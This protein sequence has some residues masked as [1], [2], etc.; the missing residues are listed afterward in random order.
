M[1]IKCR[2]D[3]AFIR[4]DAKTVEQN[5]GQHARPY[6]IYYCIL[7]CILSVLYIIMYHYV[8]YNTEEEWRDGD[9][10]SEQVIRMKQP[11]PQQEDWR[12]R[13]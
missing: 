6:I 13:W 2:N 9:P 7:L 8:Y 10:H 12:E 11:P 3:H 5:E 1:G 4:C